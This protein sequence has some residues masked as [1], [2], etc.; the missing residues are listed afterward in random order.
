MQLRPA[1]ALIFVSLM[2]GHAGTSATAS[3][4][5]GGGPNDGPIMGESSA[6]Q[7][8]QRIGFLSAVDTRKNPPDLVY[9]VCNRGQQNLV[10]R[11]KDELIFNSALHP[12]KPGYCDVGTIQQ[13]STWEKRPETRIEFGSGT[14]APPAYWPLPR[15]SSP[16]ESLVTRLFSG[17]LDT[18]PAAAVER[19]VPDQKATVE[20]KLEKKGNEA[21][22]FLQWQQNV[23]TVIL[24]LAK[25]SPEARIR[26]LEAIQ[27][28]RDK[29]YGVSLVGQ[30][31]V[32]KHF[33]G[34]PPADIAEVQRRI[35]QG[36]FILVSP[37]EKVG[38][39]LSLALSATG[40]VK[41]VQYVP[42][43]IGGTG[44][45]SGVLMGFLWA[46]FAE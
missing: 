37:T 45:K 26:L 1:L 15:P 5:S 42:V 28:R 43:L 20:I 8:A 39:S 40:Q 38:T 46:T 22:L 7:P 31:E 14:V 19:G 23:G 34:M 2:W 41:T 10:Y 24:K 3:P 29:G 11:W 17:L 32:L 4:Q 12:Q 6:V 27:S 13:V 9:E 36:D 44:P 25:Q 30:E 16:S 33:A 18:K 21:Q 35:G